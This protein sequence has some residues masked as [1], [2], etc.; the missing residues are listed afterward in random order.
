MFISK[1]FSFCGLS[2]Y[3]YAMNIESFSIYG[4]KR[5]YSAKSMSTPKKIAPSPLVRNGRVS[6]T[7]MPYFTI[8]IVCSLPLLRQNSRIFAANFA[9]ENYPS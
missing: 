9:G 2:F 5:I 4:V 8:L 6:R 1:P 3:L 7:T